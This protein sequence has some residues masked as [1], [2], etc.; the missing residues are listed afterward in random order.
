ME[1]LFHAQTIKYLAEKRYDD[2]RQEQTG[3]I[4]IPESLPEL[5]RV[6]DCFGTVL[7]QSRTVDSGSVTVSGGIQCG[8]LYVP[9]GEERLERLELWLPFT[10]TKKLPTEPG[11]VLHYWGWLRSLEARFVNARK[12]LV[13]A[14]LGSELTL[15]SPAEL[16][17]Q[18]PERCPRGLICKTETFPMRL[19]LCAAEKEVRIADEVLMP[20][21]GPGVDRL[22]KAQCA[23]EL[24]ERRVLGERVIFQG[25]LVLRVLGLTEAGEPVRWS[26]SVPFSQYADLDRSLEEDADVSA[27]PIFNHVEIDTDGQPDSRRL[28]VNLSFTVQ[29]VLRG[30]LPV[31]LTQD[32]Y[33]LDGELAPQWQRVELTPC[34]DVVETDLTQTLELPAEAVSLLDWTVFP[35]RTDAA[36]GAA[37]ARGGLGLNLLYYDGEHRL[38]GRLQ[39]RELRV[40]RQAEP[41]ADWRCVLLPGRELR[42]Q[43]RQLLLPLTAR[44]RY[45]Q[46]EALRNLC[47]AELRPL[48][49]MEGPSLIVRAASGE[50]WQI[51][52]ENGSTVRAIQTANGLEESCLREERL[53][54]IPTG[55][56][57]TSI[58]EE[59]E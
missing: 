8:V 21:D 53:L 30:E 24:G 39:R 5:D 44:Q 48:P 23:V 1:I 10:V 49:R 42:Q 15:L 20:E 13:R 41:S 35:D 45:C 37:F 25:E 16:E 32:A 19:P 54:L 33:C 38:Q 11:T 2:I 47:G 12:L 26:G 51:A 43:G 3:E 27:Q 22:L 59:S 28:L 55:R 9:A 7:V 52:R 50:L 46:T 57:V 40:E 34:L 17:L 31:T 6:V 29:L 18:Q 58:G 4:V 36:P 56:G 14:E